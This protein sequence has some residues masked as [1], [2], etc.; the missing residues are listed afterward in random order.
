MQ[1]ILAC[2]LTG[3]LLG[4]GLAIA[5]EPQATAPQPKPPRY[6]ARFDEQFT[7]ADKDGDGALTREEAA[8]AGMRRI[9][10]NFDR[11]DANRDGKVTREE[12]RA[13]LRSRVSS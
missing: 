10:E 5:T 2:M 4:A 6:V 13:L 1:F 3:G 12:V 7:A 11:L 9:V 8:N